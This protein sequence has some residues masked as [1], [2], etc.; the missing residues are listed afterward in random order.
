MLIQASVYQI[1]YQALLKNFILKYYKG[2][3]PGKGI[4]SPSVWLVDVEKFRSEVFNGEKM[5]SPTY[6]YRL[7]VDL[8]PERVFVGEINDQAF[9]YGLK[10]IGID[11]LDTTFNMNALNSM[12]SEFKSKFKVD[13]MLGIELQSKLFSEL[14][15]KVTG[16]LEHKNSLPIVLLKHQDISEA[17]NS[18]EKNSENTKANFFLKEATSLFMNEKY[19]F[20]FHSYNTFKTRNDKWNLMKLLIEFP[21]ITET[22]LSVHITHIND[23]QGENIYQNYRGKTNFSNSSSNVVVISCQSYSPTHTSHFYSR[24]LHIMLQIAAGNIL[25]GQYLNY[26]NDGNIVSGNVLLQNIPKNSNDDLVPKK[27][28][29]PKLISGNKM[30]LEDFEDVDKNILQYLYDPSLNYREIPL[31][32]KN[33]LINLELYLNDYYNS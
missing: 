21:S 17:D 28:L 24:H 4:N 16:E 1:F 25:F 9:Y 31:K 10:Y 32:A 13:I 22:D 11:S 8:N 6:F 19:W 3:I 14:N 18:L 15:D 26:R 29:I 7:K 30:Y 20:Y 5:L 33:D 23:K 2:E 27:Y 12:Y